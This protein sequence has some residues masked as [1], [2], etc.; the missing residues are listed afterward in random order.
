MPR[1][2]LNTKSSLWFLSSLKDTLV[3]RRKYIC[4]LAWGLCGEFFQMTLISFYWYSPARY[5][6]PY[7][8]SFSLIPRLLIW[9]PKYGLLGGAV[10]VN[11]RNLKNTLDLIWS[12]AFNYSISEHR[13]LTKSLQSPLSLDR[14]SSWCQERPWLDGVVCVSSSYFAVFLSGY[15]PAGSNKDLVGWCSN[16]VKS[17]LEFFLCDPIVQPELGSIQV[18]VLGFLRSI[19]QITAGDFPCSNW[20]IINEF[21]GC[22]LLRHAI[23]LPVWPHDYCVTYTKPTL[24]LSIRGRG[25]LPLLVGRNGGR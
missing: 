4:E 2:D 24:S 16:L 14:P 17:D 22:L 12:E 5:K 8:A 25:R 19:T 15:L 18:H 7:Q 1:Y 20:W 21:P 13:P 3:W 6:P 23:L 9:G 10:I 11:L